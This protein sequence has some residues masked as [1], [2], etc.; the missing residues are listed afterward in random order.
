MNQQTL[1]LLMLMC[2]SSLVLG[3]GLGFFFLLPKEGDKCESD[4]P[5][6]NST[7]YAIDEDGECVISQC[8]VGYVK[9]GRGG[10]R[11]Y[12][13]DVYTDDDDDAGRGARETDTL[14]GDDIQIPSGRYIRIKQTVAYDMGAEGDVDDQ[15]KVFKLAEVEVSNDGG[16]VILSTNKPVTGSSELTGHVWANLTDGDLTTFASTNGRDDTEY[17]FMTIDLEQ[18]EVIE[19]IVIRNDT[20][21]PERII[22]AKIQIIAEDG[23]EVIKETPLITDSA[24]SYTIVFPGNE[25]LSL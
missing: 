25:W 24:S 5:A 8:D 23:I 10:C 3:I 13:A 6:S 7:K 2:S 19:K 16:L 21:N 4:D 14:V 9:D 1:I 20:E 12:G 15:N 17:D 22:G 11:K 18:E